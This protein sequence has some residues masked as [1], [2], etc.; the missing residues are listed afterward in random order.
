VLGISIVGIPLIPAVVASIPLVALFGY[1]VGTY[2]LA[3]R[4]WTAIGDP[5]VETWPQRSL[6]LLAGLAVLTAAVLVPV[7]GWVVGV[8]VGLI[9]VG[10][11]VR[12]MISRPD[13]G[14]GR[15]P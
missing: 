2:A 8:A 11:T 12:R 4:V 10:A 3:E 13:A 7:L 5:L 1:L 9:G 6:I 15:A 14:R